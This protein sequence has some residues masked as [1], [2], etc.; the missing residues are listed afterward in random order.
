MYSKRK[1]HIQ[2]TWRGIEVNTLPGSGQELWP[3]SLLIVTLIVEQCFVV[4]LSYTLPSL[5]KRG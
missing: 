1:A 3:W 4:F 5:R 2:V